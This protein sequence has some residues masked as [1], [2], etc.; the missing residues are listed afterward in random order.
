MLS[1]VD[2]IFLQNQTLAVSLHISGV[3]LIWTGSCLTVGRNW[4]TNFNTI[5]TL[6]TNKEY[7]ENS[8]TESPTRRSGLYSITTVWKNK[9]NMSNKFWTPQDLRV[10]MDT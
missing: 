6:A 9:D 5:E 7:I 1:A 2:C 8:L 3:A 10:K 4:T